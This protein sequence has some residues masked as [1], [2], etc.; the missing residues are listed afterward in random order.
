MQLPSSVNFSI[1]LLRRKDH[2]LIR[3]KPQPLQYRK[4]QSSALQEVFICE[5]ISVRDV[6]ICS[7]LVGY[8]VCEFNILRQYNTDILEID[9]VD[10]LSS[11]CRA[12][13]CL[14]MELKKFSFCEGVN[15][16]DI[17]CDCLASWPASSLH[18]TCDTFAN[19]N[20][21]LQKLFNIIPC[22]NCLCSSYFVILQ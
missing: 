14:N 3:K 8:S 18:M 9:N 5:N 21:L 11:S 13:A 6:S 15:E 19:N 10:L 22:I 2:H 12:Q 7:Q 4:N 1:K 20:T 17:P 16:F